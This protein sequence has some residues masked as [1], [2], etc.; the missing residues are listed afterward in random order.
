MKRLKAVLLG[1]IALTLTGCGNQDMF[2]TQFTFKRAV[3]YQGGGEQTYN[4]KKWRTYED[5]EQVQITTYDGDVF[6]LSMN[7][8]RLE[9]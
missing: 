2:D 8:C 1:V 9:G 3:C 4:I 5:G 7:Y 6:L